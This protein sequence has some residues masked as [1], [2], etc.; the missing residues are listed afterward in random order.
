MTRHEHETTTRPSW[1]RA[2]RGEVAL[3]VGVGLLGGLFLAGLTITA[4][5]G[6]WLP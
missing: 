6:A 2:N 4:T 3:W 1:A 5:I